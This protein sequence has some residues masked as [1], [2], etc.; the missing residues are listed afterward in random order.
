MDIVYFKDLAIG[1]GSLV[2]AF[3]LLTAGVIFLWKREWQPRL[4]L[5]IDVDA[6]CKIRDSFLIEPVCVVENVGLLR[7]YIYK[8]KFSVRYILPEDKLIPGDENKL[9]KATIFPGT[10][11]ST[12][13][14]K[15][16]W[17]W[18]YVEAGIA[19]RFS[20]VTHIPENAVA[21]LVWVKL[22]HKK[23]KDDFFTT[24]K[25]FVIE[26]GNLIKN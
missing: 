12:Q 8:L 16:T 18:S 2:T 6:F 15:D 13:L 23:S 10:A 17:K 19:R 11:V 21:V 22:F 1:I 25:V 4:K 9:L 14:V 5:S 7:C 3:S 24:Q 26:N 20:N